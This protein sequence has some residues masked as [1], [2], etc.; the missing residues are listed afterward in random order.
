MAVLCVSPAEADPCGMVPPLTIATN[1]RAI[2]RIGVQR[3]YVSYRNG[4]ET[5][6]LRPGFSGS[7]DNFGMLIPFPSPP[8]IRKVDDDIFAHIEAAI[9]PPSVEMTITRQTGEVWYDG[10][11]GLIGAK[12]TQNGS[13]GLGSRG[14]GLGGGGLA[15]SEVNVV[16]QEAVG[17]YQ[18][19]VIEAGSAEALSNWMAE[20][21]YRYPE[22]MDDVANE[23]VADGWYFV[24]VKARVGSAGSVAPKPGMRAADPQLPAGA[25]FDGHVQ[26]MGFRFASTEPVI[27]MRLS[28][29]NG[30][31]AYNVVYMLSERPLRIDGLDESFVTARLSGQTLHSHLT[32]PLA[33]TARSG[34]L[35]WLTPEMTAEVEA[36]RDPSPVLHHARD[37]FAADMLAVRTG[38]LSLSVEDDEKALLNISERLGLR[39][40][41]IDDLHASALEDAREE[42]VSAALDDVREMHLTVIAGTI[43]TELIRDENLT[44]VTDTRSV[45]EQDRR[46]DPLKLSNISGAAV[47]RTY[48]N[49]HSLSWSEAGPRP[50][51]GCQSGLCEYTLRLDL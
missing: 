2:E 39:G 34:E 43:P 49:T 45:S 25:S 48:N 23:Y 36:R 31:D 29:F 40:E 26:G 33:L 12:G 20:N 5:M 11:G 3:T 32:Q 4:V 7:I 8:A 19:A 38:S 16:N 17:M 51:R 37:L 42:A 46:H 18:V 44:F 14:L 41:D 50:C 21:G 9:S 28:V 24:A 35:S 30:E 47:V 10:I 1:Q 22:G 13:G 15:Y 6:V 27:P